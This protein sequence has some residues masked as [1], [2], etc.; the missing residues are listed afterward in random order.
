M[1]SKR[2]YLNVDPDYEDV[3]EQQNKKQ[4]LIEKD[5]KAET[6][7]KIE[8]IIQ[9]QIAIEIKEKENELNIV[10]QS[11]Y[12]TR[13]LLDRLRACLVA[14]Y[15]SNESIGNL[16]QQK[17]FVS[18]VPS[19]HPAVKK[20][21]GK[22]PSYS[23]DQWL[24][25]C[26][27]RGTNESATDVKLMNGSSNS[28]QNPI[29]VVES[30]KDPIQQPCDSSTKLEP[31]I[32]SG[33]AS[34]FRVK[35]KLIVG[36]IS[37]F[38]PPDR[39]EESDPSTHK[40][41]IYIRGT[42]EE[43][44]IDHYVKKVWFFLHPSYRPNDLVEVVHPPFHLSRR[45]WGEFPIR[46]QL[47][48]HDQRN[49]R[50]DIIHHLKL[51][52][53]Y[54]GLQ[55]FG[56]ETTVEIEIEKGKPLE[57]AVAIPSSASLHLPSVPKTQFLNDGVQTKD[58]DGNSQEP[59]LKCDNIKLSTP[60]EIDANTNPQIMIQNGND[61]VFE[62]KKEVLGLP[63]LKNSVLPRDSSQSASNLN[64]NK[65]P[66]AC[67]SSTSNDT[68]LHLVPEISENVSGNNNTTFPLVSSVIPCCNINT[69]SE[70]TAIQGALAAKG[71]TFSAANP[72]ANSVILTS[73]PVT[74]IAASSM[75]TLTASSLPISTASSL[76]IS[77][78]TSL[79][80]LTASS[81]P[82][83][84]A[85][86]SSTLT[87]PSISTILKESPVTLTSPLSIF[88]TVPEST[89]AV[90]AAP[91]IT[92]LAL[93]MF[94]TTPVST[95]TAASVAVSTMTSTNVSKSAISCSTA[96]P[97][98]VTLTSL[99]SSKLSVPVTVSKPKYGSTTTA[100]TSTTSVVGLTATT[101]TISTASS[102][103][104]TDAMLAPK[105]ANLQA[106]PVPMKVQN[107]QNLPLNTLL[108]C[109]TSQGKV[110]LMSQP[111]TGNPAT[112][113]P[114][115]ALVSTPASTT[116]P[117]LIQNNSTSATTSTTSSFKP[118]IAISKMILA[119]NA[120]K[121]VPNSVDVRTGD[122]CSTKTYTIQ[123]GSSS[124]LSAA[125]NQNDNVIK[126]KI[127][128]NENTPI[129]SP[130]RVTPKGLISIPNST[131]GMCWPSS[132]TIQST[133]SQVNKPNPV[134]SHTLFNMGSLPQA[135]ILPSS[136][137]SL[138]KVPNTTNTSV[139]LLSS[140]PVNKNT[141]L[142]SAKSPIKKTVT[143][144]GIFIPTVTPGVVR[145]LV[146][147]T[148]STPGK[149]SLL[150][151]SSGVGGF[152]KG[153][154][155]ASNKIIQSSP[156]VINSV[157]VSNTSGTPSPVQPFIINSNNCSI[158]PAT[159]LPLLPQSSSTVNAGMPNIKT[160][161][162]SGEWKQPVRCNLVSN[163]SS[164]QTLPS[165]FSSGKQT[166]VLTTT[167]NKGLSLLPSH[168]FLKS[169][170]DIKSDASQSL[171]TKPSTSNINTTQPNMSAVVS[172]ANTVAASSSLLNT[173]KPMLILKNPNKSA[174]IVAPVNNS[175]VP[176]GKVWPSAS[177][178]EKPAICVTN[179]QDMTNSSVPLQ[180]LQVQYSNG[181]L[182]LA[183]PSGFSSNN[184]SQKVLLKV[185]PSTSVCNSP[186]SSL[187][188]CSNGTIS[189]STVTT[190]VCS[191]AFPKTTSV[192]AKQVRPSMC[193]KKIHGYNK[194]KKIQPINQSVPAINLNALTDMVSV[195]RAVVR[196][197]PVVCHSVDRSLH[198]Y[199]TD[200][201][202]QW[203]SWNIG[204]RRASEWQRASSVKNYILKLVSG[205]TNF[206]AADVWST[207]QIFTW[208]RLHA[209]SP[210]HLEKQL[211]PSESSSKC[212]TESS[213]TIQA[214]S[215]F[216]PMESLQKKLE[217]LEVSTASLCDEHFLTVDVI[218]RSNSGLPK[219]KL[220]REDDADTVTS[221]DYMYL[222]SPEVSNFVHETARQVGVQFKPTK[223]EDNI[224][225]SSCELM[226]YS[227][228]ENLM[229]DIVRTAFALKSKE[230][231]YPTNLS[232]PDIH[233]A[234]KSIPFC[235]FLTNANLG[236]VVDADHIQPST[237]Y[238]QPSAD[239]SKEKH[240]IT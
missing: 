229:S 38:I 93:S 198:P 220:K 103:L 211:Q 95:L 86:S 2:G 137:M 71:L 210:H 235:D 217:Q 143:Q 26:Q 124:N 138:S 28:S 89:L 208:C 140:S 55:T 171:L 187:P 134:T 117:S 148:K 12:Q 46:V 146:S 42:K 164:L 173:N 14:N 17:T 1:N 82:I 133:L 193:E 20:H 109:L 13:H 81:L 125:T 37:K 88:N 155:L 45:G 57:S 83:L 234:L 78:A 43:P 34:R 115:N 112:C 154:L 158:S 30:C 120:V 123:L 224:Y 98:F 22:K 172:A 40:W 126:D 222:P 25:K 65:L 226:I 58:P 144:P 202:E 91:S 207:K 206:S 7:Q 99:P 96:L 35:K 79:P 56:A 67:S 231:R 41:L 183:P 142:L 139:I 29:P 121:K 177:S 175:P 69:T 51:D 111:L 15:Y 5:A 240:G 200:T 64:V 63:C 147:E 113:L 227:C 151:L 47:H 182:V 195:I 145:P 192:I 44:S 165:T 178:V 90:T 77:T 102:A 225:S 237:D 205:S 61:G 152:N 48:F 128:K 106:V 49:K 60:K 116:I 179:S 24:E 141:S 150:L 54:T 75:S 129:I 39:R 122:G 170:S 201:V 118:P 218:S 72:T 53:T 85:A 136:H 203:L 36:N 230:G 188:K 221:Q 110:L 11:I 184:S 9:K 149:S 19:I 119:N 185:I 130:F 190:T 156:S 107:L 84:S 223:I 87:E 189:L 213:S 76:P 132:G 215:S 74:T 18:A 239:H 100:I 162:R 169:N 157:S 4:R 105:P 204:K 94:T 33:R 159:R 131:L 32:T 191:S 174:M 127:P 70:K 232:L 101:V 219:V 160:L 228:L 135:N 23:D 166:Y 216:T 212:F 10:D 97:Y 104:P 62:L 68:S 186:V 236:L 238:I 66:V 161:A 163:S 27:W 21:L 194:L 108:K 31:E 199:A 176:T 80:T 233:R 3:S 209:Y 73:T 50:V 168:L 8:K 6:I 52:R 153:P 114:A 197:H 167:R 214:L 196:L 181:S 180:S 92:T 59:I 16:S